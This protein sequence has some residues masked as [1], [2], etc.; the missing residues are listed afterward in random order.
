[1]HRLAT[2]EGFLAVLDGHAAKFAPGQQFSYCNGG[3]VLLALL[4]ERSTGMGFH[5]LDEQHV[6]RPAG[7][8]DTAFLRSDELPGR[9]ALGYVGADG[10]RTNV[11]HLPVRGNGDGGIYTT[12]ADVR[13]MWTAFLAGSIVSSP[14]IAEMVRSRRNAGADGSAHERG[15]AT[16][17]RDAA[18]DAE[19]AAPRVHPAQHLVER[20]PRERSR[21]GHVDRCSQARARRHEPPHNDRREEGPQRH[22]RR[23]RDRDLTGLAVAE[24]PVERAPGRALEGGPRCGR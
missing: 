5:E 23:L 21:A 19:H 15:D 24:H 17:D 10:L 18:G 3:Y 20:P 14:S 4:A 22:V 9:A 2:T 6:C 16:D 1:M 8:H 7:M 13:L 12:A 11:L